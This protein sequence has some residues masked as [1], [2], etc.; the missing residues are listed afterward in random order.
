LQVSTG[1]PT[2]HDDDHQGSNENED[3]HQGSN[4]NEDDRQYSNED[5]DDD[6]YYTDKDN[7]EQNYRDSPMDLQKDDNI[8]FDINE[9]FVL[10]E[11]IDEASPSEDGAIA[12]AALRRPQGL[13]HNI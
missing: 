6:I 2:S 12:R 5:E 8:C 1:K 13:V 10:P 11:N 9:G 3:D 7:S 4:E